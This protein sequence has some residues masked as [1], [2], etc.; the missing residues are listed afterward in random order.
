MIKNINAVDCF[1][2]LKENS[3]AKLID[4]RTPE[5]WENDGCPD[6]SSI[7]K[8][9]YFV[10][11]NNVNFLNEIKNLNF[12]VDDTVF[13]ICRSGSRS[14]HAIKYL[15]NIIETKKLF[16]VEGGIEIGW[17]LNSLPIKSFYCK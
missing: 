14:W 10:C 11:W 16:N 8:K 13:F 17:K 9:L 7:G 15:S 5:E 12:G 2:I 6:L 1:R 4:V 3:N